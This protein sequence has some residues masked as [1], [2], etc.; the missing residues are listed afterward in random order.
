MFTDR[1][2]RF[3]TRMRVARMATAD[4]TGQPHAI[5]IVFATDGQRL[6]TPLDEKPKRLGPKQLKRV[7]NLLEN[8]RVA[9]VLDQYDEDWSRLAW[10]IVIGRGGVVEDGAVH[11]TG[12]QLL[13]EKYPQY[14]AMP[15]DERP[16]IVV[17]PERVTSWGAL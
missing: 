6:Y 12:V 8:P 4:A 10:L 1:E 14:R 17:T 11:A 15:L 5:P 2:M 7:R 16:L 13:H 9:I 3:V